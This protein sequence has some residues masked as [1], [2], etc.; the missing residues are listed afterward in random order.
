MGTEWSTVPADYSFPERDLWSSKIIAA[1]STVD[2]KAVAETPSELH[3]TPEQF[4]V[5]PE[6]VQV[7]NDSWA[8]VADN[9]AAKGLGGWTNSYSGGTQDE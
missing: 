6:E 8:P 9:E 7:D 1:D 5:L 3:L 2:F 4:D